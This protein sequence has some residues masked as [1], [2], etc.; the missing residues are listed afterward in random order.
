M[1]RIY[2]DFY[3][4][5]HVTVYIQNRTPHR[6]LEKKTPEGVFTGK[7]PKVSHL[8]IFSSIAYCH[9]LDDKRTKLDQTPEK[10]FFIGYIE[11]SKVFRIY[12]PRNR[13]IVVR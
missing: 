2:P 3:G 10:G 13:K 9:M 8:R 1:T 7:K 4:K 12:I 11:S 5:K 6:V